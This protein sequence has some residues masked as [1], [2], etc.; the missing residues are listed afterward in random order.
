MFYTQTPPHGPPAQSTTAA[1]AAVDRTAQDARI[2]RLLGGM[3]H[4]VSFL[5]GAVWQRQSM[6]VPPPAA[7]PALPQGPPALSALPQGLKIRC[8]RVLCLFFIRVD[9]NVK[10]MRC[11][12]CVD[13]RVDT[14]TRWYSLPVDSIAF[15]VPPQGHFRQGAL[16]LGA[17]L[18]AVQGVAVAAVGQE[19]ASPQG[20]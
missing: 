16:S 12:H 6:P 15:S 8:M 11:I 10:V 19:D 20:V 18:T 7:L 3:E 2:E 9:P 5:T 1:V 4:L 13:T 17:H 14:F